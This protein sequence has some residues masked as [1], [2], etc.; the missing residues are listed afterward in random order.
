MP[1]GSA[2]ADVPSSILGRE[3]PAE[4]S[5]GLHDFAR[6]LPYPDGDTGVSDE[7]CRPM[8]ILLASCHRYPAFGAKGS[9]RKPNRYPSGSGYHLHDLLAR[10]LVGEGHEVLYYLRGGS[11][12]DLPAG[13][14]QV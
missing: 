11:E 6:Q 9:G 5:E 10:G 12:T 3:G 4:T 13:V 14:R 2:A 1:E 7:R 8:R